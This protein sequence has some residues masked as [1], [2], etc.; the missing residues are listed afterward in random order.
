MI[1]ESA[2]NVRRKVFTWHSWFKP[3]YSFF[4]FF[5]RPNWGA[6][7]KSSNMI[8][9]K[10]KK[11]K[12]KE[13][14]V[15]RLKRFSHQNFCFVHFSTNKIRKYLSLYLAQIIN[16]E[17]KMLTMSQELWRKKKKKKRESNNYKFNCFFV[18]PEH[19]SYTFFFVLP[20]QSLDYIY[21]Y[22]IHT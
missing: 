14:K 9:I 2:T 18:C 8:F 3:I 22:L 1:V 7:Y 20:T 4:F 10:K 5:K 15:I 17:K 21:L 13:K 12:K 11:K 6:F 19:K 16:W